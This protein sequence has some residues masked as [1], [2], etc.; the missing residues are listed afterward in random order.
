MR[1]TD[2]RWR[3]AVFDT[4]VALVL[5]ALVSGPAIM[6]TAPLIRAGR[7]VFRMMGWV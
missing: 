1:R 7:R 3:G 5:I 2:K 4:G 6:L